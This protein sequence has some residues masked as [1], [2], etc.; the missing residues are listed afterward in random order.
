MNSRQYA[1]IVECAEMLI[2]RGYEKNMSLNELVEHLIKIREQ[3]PVDNVGLLAK[4]F[5]E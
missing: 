1:E 4:I 3:N 5:K 2:N